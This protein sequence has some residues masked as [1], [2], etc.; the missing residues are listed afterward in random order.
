MMLTGRALV[1]TKLCNKIRTSSLGNAT[2]AV[3]SLILH[4]VQSAWNVENQHAIFVSALE[5]SE[6]WANL[7][8]QRRGS[9]APV[10]IRKK[11]RH[12]E[13]KKKSSA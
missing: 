1:I 10:Q 7:K 11:Q 4:M 3:E 12:L 13:A 6:G 9:A 8:Y 2:P 5:S